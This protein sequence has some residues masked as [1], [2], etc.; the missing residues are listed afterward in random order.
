MFTLLLEPTRTYGM[1]GALHKATPGGTNAL[2]ANV[3]GSAANGR[4]FGIPP[5]LPCGSA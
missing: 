1:R 2:I 5:M 3:Q 4:F